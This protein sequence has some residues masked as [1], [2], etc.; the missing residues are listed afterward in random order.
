MMAR[1]TYVPTL[2]APPYSKRFTVNRPALKFPFP[3]ADPNV[4]RITTT[5]TKMRQVQFGLKFVF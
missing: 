2:E 4:G 3:F 1:E 5:S